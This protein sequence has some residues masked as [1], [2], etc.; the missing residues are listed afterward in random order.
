MFSKLKSLNLFGRSPLFSAL[1]LVLL[2]L[3]PIFLTRV[4]QKNSGPPGFVLSSEDNSEDNEDNGDES[5]DNENRDDQDDDEDTKNS[6]NKGRGSDDTGDSDDDEEDAEKTETKVEDKEETKTV[7]TVVNTDGTT[8]EIKRESSNG[9]TEV[10]IRT[11]DSSGRLLE[12]RKVETEKEGQQEVEVKTFGPLGNVLKEMKLETEQ[13]EV[14]LSIKEGEL[15]ISKVEYDP[16]EGVLEVKAGDEGTAD[17]QNKLKIKAL[18]NNFRLERAGIGVLTNFPLTVNDDTGEVFVQTPA[19]EVNLKAMPDTIVQ[20]ARLADKID[21]V[22]EVTLASEETAELEYV[23]SGTKA[24]KLLG[25][26]NLQIPVQ[27]VYDAQ[28]GEFV[29]SNQSFV[30]RLL[31]LFSF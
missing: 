4:Y 22:D 7:E 28:A 30:S 15:N 11:F 2:L 1:L 20:K 14:D 27:L 10:E 24:E 3:F 13:G 6:Q 18:G 31:D 21:E 12:T 9:E 8:S 26:F 23:L 5:G 19:G 29:K 16:A 17:G 25:V